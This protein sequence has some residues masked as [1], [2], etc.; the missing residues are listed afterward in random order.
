MRLKAQIVVNGGVA[1]GHAMT[2]HRR[3]WTY[4]DDDYEADQAVP[5]DQKTRFSKMLDEAHGYAKGL[6]NPAYL[7][8]VTVSWMWM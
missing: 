7:N 2:E 5:K 6:S 3:H 8:W 4:T 1:I